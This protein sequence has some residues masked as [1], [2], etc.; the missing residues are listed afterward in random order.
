MP[1]RSGLRAVYVAILAWT[2]AIPSLAQPAIQVADLVTATSNGDGTDSM[3]MLAAGGTVYFRGRDAAHGWELWRS[4]GTAESTRLVRDI[5]PGSC[6]SS[7]AELSEIGGVVYFL[8]GDGLTGREL[9]KSD[10]TA[11]GTLLVRDLCP[12]PCSALAGLVRA[13]DR[14]FFRME[15]ASGLEL[16]TSDGTRAGT[17][18]VV[19]LCPGPC[20]G[21]IFDLTAVGTEVAFRG[22]DGI[23]GLEPWRSDGTP[24]GTS[25]LFDLCEGPCSTGTQNHRET[26][27][28]LHQGAIFI[29]RPARATFCWELWTTDP[30]LRGDG[31]PPRICGGSTSFPPRLAE[32]NGALY[33][34]FNPGLW[35]VEV[36]PL[37]FQQVAGF[38]S[39]VGNLTPMG[40][41][42][43][44]TAATAEFGFEIWRSD[45]TPSGTE[46][47][48]DTERGIAWGNP[49][50]LTPAGDRLYFTSQTN[51]LD[52]DG[53]VLWVSDGTRGRT[54]EVHPSRNEAD[55]SRLG[56]LTPV[57][58]RLFFSASRPGTGRELWMTEG[59]DIPPSPSLVRDLH[60]SPGSSDPAGLAAIDGTLLFG[61]R[62]P[63]D[64]TSP[65]S[66]WRS[67]G[68]AVGTSGLD[69][70]GL[71]SAATAFDGSLF[72]DTGFQLFA[73]DGTAAGTTRFGHLSAAEMQPVG[74]RLF[75]SA[76]GAIPADDFG[77]EL[78]VSDGT[79]DGTRLV[80]DILPGHDNPGPLLYIPKS[81][82]PRGL[83]PLGSG[84]L[85]AAAD[86]EHGEEL[87]QSD[88][89]KAGTTLVKD[90]C[91]GTCSPEIAEPTALSARVFFTAHD[92]TS[93]RELW[94]SDGTAD[95]TRLLLDLIPGPE[96]SAPRD[97]IVFRGKLL[98]F[99]DDEAGQEKLWESDGTAAGTSSVAVTAAA[100]LPRTRHEPRIVGDR[101][102]FTAWTDAAGQELW[103]TDGTSPGT[104]LVADVLPGPASSYPH[105]LTAVGRTLLFAADDGQTGH[106]LWVSTGTAAGTRRLQDIA[107]G[108]ASSA[109]AEMTQAGSKIFF[110]ADGGDQGRELW[111]LNEQDL[112][113]ATSCVPAQDR[114]CL[115]GGR[116]G[117]KVRW[118]DHHNG[119]RE[120]VG[121][122]VPESSESGFFWFFDA[123]NLELVVKVL[124]GGA[125]NGHSW[126][127]YG[128]LSDVEYDVTVTDYDSG[129]Q[130]TYHNPPGT[131][132]G[133]ADTSAFPAAPPPAA[134]P[135]F[136]LLGASAMELPAPE[137]GAGACVSSPEAL[138]LLEDRFRVE[139]RWK[140][141]HDGTEG[142][143][144][145]VPRTGQ[146]GSF[147][148]FAPGNI[149]L[150][151]K[152]LDG[153]PA[154]GKFW[155]FYG[156]LSDVEYTI[157][158][159]DTAMGAVKTYHNP[160]GSYCGRADTRAF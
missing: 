35:K 36:R 10:G 114:L 156:A 123:G 55:F 107:P 155:F 94:V 12:G 88:G 78:W 127:F 98:F 60:A 8:A 91:P 39:G 108:P 30:A 120:G 28:F 90:L 146:T 105:G 102:Y 150:L 25:L 79:L 145:T 3:P 125:S 154:G 83:T 2:I 16:W 50:N 18:R 149:E 97:L 22:E 66:V 29:W 57:A 9:W 6:D 140:N 26:A 77:K 54:R 46:L 75:L 109:P 80:R 44:F 85:F 45:G 15:D 41:S 128:A 144:T 147:W 84:V 31:P 76:S 126:F 37:R 137:A 59:P 158:V 96:S 13:G 87:W 48:R 70:P 19:D 124:D 56:A 136:V 142:V 21:G 89:T 110:A 33:F 118:R 71:P 139:A 63:L 67:D 43:F 103:L 61:A 58:G 152:I 11:T 100:G 14:F 132:C 40:S 130:K 34:G 49:E 4:D 62:K 47:L 116:F 53:Q 92:T 112:P 68:T 119:S 95:G 20:S 117:V 52:P 69:E 73:T 17:H 74:G 24:E 151:V 72:F 148:F 134:E 160:P 159:T 51:S 38:L 111:V 104:R 113:E 135:D 82:A 93:G 138:C 64:A 1:D 7:P 157:T 129:A 133:Q 115:A 121:T 131:L 5:C 86:E 122:A 32:L 153:R 81:S 101:L 141:Q 23:H 65:F 99:A 27:F 143:A 42:L 106:E